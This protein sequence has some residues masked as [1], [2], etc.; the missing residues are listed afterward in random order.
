MHIEARLTHEAF[1]LSLPW[2]AEQTPALPA[3]SAGRGG[4]ASFQLILAADQRCA[5]TLD[6]TPWCSHL[7]AMPTLRLAARA[8]FP[9][10]LWLEGMVL[11][12]ERT[13]RA[14][15]LLSQS[16]LEQAAGTPLAVWIEVSVPATAEVGP[17]TVDIDI[18]GSEMLGDEQLLR[19]LSAQVAVYSTA[20]P[21]ISASPFV[22]DL[23]QHNANLA[24][25]YEVPLW[26]DA[27]FAVMAQFLRALAA[28]GQSSM[29][30]VASEIPWRGQGCDII[31]RNPSN[32][33]EYNMVRVR[34]DAEGRFQYDF[35]VLQRYV[36][37]C[38]SVGIR[39]EIALFGLIN[40]WRDDR[41]DANL[42]IDWPENLLVRYVDEADGC[43]HYLQNEAEI[44]AY[45]RALA[46]FLAEKGWR[47][48]TR[49]VADEPSDLPR[50]QH[51]MEKLRA[52]MP[53]FRYKGAF[54]RTPLLKALLPGVDTV[55]PSLA[56][57]SA[58]APAIAEHRRNHPGAQALW[59]VCWTPAYPNTM[60]ANHLLEG[61]F[62]PWLTYA[63]GLDGFL[64]WSF[65]C[66][67]KAPRQD[68]RYG[69]W[70]AGD[71]LLVY[72][73]N[74]GTPLL[75]LRYKALQ[76]GLEDY[77]LLCAARDA[78]RQDDVAQALRKLV[79]ETKPEHF[80][81]PDLLPREALFSTRYELYEAARADL[82]RGLSL[83]KRASGVYND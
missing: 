45:L 81:A 49:I 24:R 15:I 60:L 50:Y 61:R 80:F 28:L 43:C 44:A 33:F 63:L 48:R 71:L 20:M 36:E 55:I 10:A 64:R 23:W 16:A 72:P 67:P 62:I 34:R 14:D 2:S 47:E 11:D 12:D 58:A 38:D 27:H 1:Q 25:T 7:G 46:A 35:S 5:I 73:G 75:S 69:N 30:V 65:T 37:L 4:T 22:L 26:S 40:I 56:C 53:G 83:A 77:A 74:A 6:S 66:W 19:T 52:N 76:R 13:A 21:K 70:P 59:Y 3:L 79:P 39:G 82:L 42:T 32:M 68:I 29:T 54:D 78:G 31:T 41:H 9:V 57:L 8:P 51:S 18:F 17:V